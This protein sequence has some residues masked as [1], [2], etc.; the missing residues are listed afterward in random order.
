MQSNSNSVDLTPRSSQDNKISEDQQPGASES[1]AFDDSASSTGHLCQTCEPLRESGF[2]LR[3]KAF[4]IFTEAR[5]EISDIQKKAPTCAFCLLLSR[6]IAQVLR[7]VNFAQ[8][9]SMAQ[10]SSRY[11]GPTPDDIV[12]TRYSENAGGIQRKFKWDLLKGQVCSTDN[13]TAT[14]T[15]GPMRHDSNRYHPEFIRKIQSNAIDFSVIPLWLQR[16]EMD[17]RQSCRSEGQI[18][19]SPPECFRVYDVQEQKIVNAPKECRYVALSYR[20]G[21][22]VEQKYDEARKEGMMHFLALNA[23][24]DRSHRYAC[25]NSSSRYQDHETD[26]AAIHLDRCPMYQ[27]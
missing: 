20:W 13:E 2:L 8:L 3:R 12:L 22:G 16:C 17:H 9:P 27:P 18:G 26:Q 25:S 11:Y 5:L 14:F 24:F 10:Q 6:T 15:I 23:E 7:P 4:S 1:H 19:T 21:V